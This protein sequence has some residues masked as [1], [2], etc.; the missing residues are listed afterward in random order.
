M[1]FILDFE[2]MPD[3]ILIRTSGPADVSGFERL[4]LALLNSPGWITGTPQVVDHRGLDL[5][6][7][8]PSEVKKVVDIIKQSIGGLGNG[9]CAFVMKDE[10]G[11]GFARMY[12]LSGGDNLHAKVEV[13][14][15]LRDAL[16]WIKNHKYPI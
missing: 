16:A 15:S 11:F 9:I 2:N 8:E 3:Y 6:V 4:M 14:Y 1:E 7:I 13:F 12:E 10:L 5:T